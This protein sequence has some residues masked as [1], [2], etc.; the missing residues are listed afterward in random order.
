M[1]VVRTTNQIGVRHRH[2][3]NKPAKPS[4]RAIK[5]QADFSQAR[6]N[7]AHQGSSSMRIQTENAIVSKASCRRKSCAFLNWYGPA[8]RVQARQNR[9]A[10]A[11]NGIVNR[12]S[13]RRSFC[14]DDH[15]IFSSLVANADPP[16]VPQEGR[17]RLL[18][19]EARGQAVSRY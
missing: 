13:I 8:E 19:A 3:S 16:R 4:P 18:A 5:K 17:Q 2:H 11:S 12:S 10:I 9:C 7:L 6:N 14:F 1:T 15:R